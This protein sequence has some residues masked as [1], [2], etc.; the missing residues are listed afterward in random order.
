MHALAVALPGAAWARAAS[1]CNRPG[2]S[3]L[4]P[5]KRKRSRRVRAIPSPPCFAFRARAGSREQ[6]RHHFTA[7]VGQAE[8]AALETIGQLQVIQAEQ[9]QDGGMEIVDV[10]LVLDGVPADLVGL[11]EHLAAP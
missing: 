11:A 8:V 3:R 6:L 7:H 2:D 10:D 1:R 9:V 5:P 4:T